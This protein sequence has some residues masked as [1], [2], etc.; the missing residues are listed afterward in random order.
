MEENIIIKYYDTC[1]HLQ[2]RQLMKPFVEWLIDAEEETDE[3]SSE[4]SGGASDDSD[5]ESNKDKN[6]PESD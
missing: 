1:D 6:E 2:I 3:E 4:A 5:Y